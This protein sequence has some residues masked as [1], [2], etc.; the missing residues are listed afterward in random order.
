MRNHGASA[1]R[2]DFSRDFWRVE[3]LKNGTG[4]ESDR[5]C[6]P[7][8][9]ISL[10]RIASRNGLTGKTIHGDLIQIRDRRRW[11]GFQHG[12]PSD[13]LLNRLGRKSA[14]PPHFQGG[15]FEG[16]HEC[17]DLQSIEIFFE[18]VREIIGDQRICVSF[19]FA[20]PRIYKLSPLDHQ[21][22]M[23]I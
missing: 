20:L 6:S 14:V 1:L 3:D 13:D 7:P 15:A 4:R 18:E 8:D 11:C 12:A 9:V 10:N 21:P 23:T 5:T 19:D 16:I 2:S 17:T 22:G